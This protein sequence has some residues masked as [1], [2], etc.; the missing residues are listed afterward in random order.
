MCCCML[1]D[2]S[3]ACLFVAINGALLSGSQMIWLNQ[4][5]PKTVIKKLPEATVFMACQRFMC[6]CWRTGLTQKWRVTCG[7]SFPARPL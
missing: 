5:D 1:A 3:C 4:F 6:V 2:L 7:S